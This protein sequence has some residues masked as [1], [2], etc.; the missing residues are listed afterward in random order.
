MHVRDAR[1]GLP[2]GP[3][4]GPLAQTV[5]LH[6]DPLGVLRRARERHGDVFTLRL[7]TARPIVVVADPAQVPALAAAD[8]GRARAGSARRRIVPMASPRSIF[9]GDG[10]GHEAARG[11]V[12]PLF[13]RDAVAAHRAAMAAIA[14]EHVERWPRGRPFRL[15]PRMRALVDEVFVRLLLGVGDERRAPAIAAA[16]GRMLWTPGN[17]PLSLPGEGDG[18]MGAGATALFDRRKAPLARL[19]AE[20]VDRRRGDPGAAD[21]IG[22]M[23]RSD[24]AQPTEAIVDELLPLLMAAQ[25]PPAAALTWLLDRLGRAPDLAERFLADEDADGARGGF[26][27]AVVRETLRLR[28]PAVAVLRRLAEPAD[29][30]GRR[31]PAGVVTML[32]TAL[33]HRDPRAFADPDAFRPDRWAAGDVLDAAFFPFGGGARRCLGEHL[34]NAYID[35]L[36]PVILRRVRLEPLWPVPER[37][38]LRGTILVPQRS[39]PV[40]AGRLGLPAPGRPRE[41]GR[42]AGP[43]GRG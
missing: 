31:L 25:E 21:V 33:V 2:A 42:P 18:L 11:R 17:P 38:V 6:R 7:L 19:L 34:A 27:D 26:R 15:L 10:R 24:P 5:A 9:G 16:I 43:G 4:A 8:P 32:P 30:A 1:H 36:T 23:L 39:T 37:M 40:R 29:V 35:G 3:E 13:A 14:V 28:P 41:G 22:R 12:A 20:E